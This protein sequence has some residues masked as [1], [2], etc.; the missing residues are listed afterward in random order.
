M[1]SNGATEV[2]IPADVSPLRSSKY[3]SPE[4]VLNTFRVFSPITFATPKA[5]E[6]FLVFHM[7]QKGRPWSKANK[8]YETSQAKYD[9]DSEIERCNYEYCR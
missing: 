2:L 3:V 8:G 7:P 1:K 6:N 4:S 9:E 5:L